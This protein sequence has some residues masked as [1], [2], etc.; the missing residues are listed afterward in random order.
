[1]NQFAIILLRTDTGSPLGLPL[2]QISLSA[3]KTL[4]V[5]CPRQAV[6]RDVPQ[7]GFDL[8]SMVPGDMLRL[9]AVT[10]NSLISVLLL[11]E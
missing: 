7:N 5:T 10:E 1:M 6:D 8:A 3:N 11:F 4:A 2:G 9:G